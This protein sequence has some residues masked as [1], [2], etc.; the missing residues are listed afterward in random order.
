MYYPPIE[1]MLVSYLENANAFLN[2]VFIRQLHL[3]LY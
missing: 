2:V 3:T 1:S